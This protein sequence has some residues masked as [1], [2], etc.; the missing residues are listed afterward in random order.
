MEVEGKV[1][2]LRHA[3][4]WLTQK[5]LHDAMQKIGLVAVNPKGEAFNP[6]LHEAMT[7]IESPDV[8]SHTIIDVIQT[9]T[10]K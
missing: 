1:K 6:E 4:S 7:M 10:S 8:E 3:Q 5:L 2:P 9:D